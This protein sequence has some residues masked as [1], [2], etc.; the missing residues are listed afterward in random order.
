VRLFA[1]GGRAAAGLAP[2][3]IA[4]NRFLAARD[5]IGGSFV[6]LA[7]PRLQS[8]VERLVAL[9]D[10]CRPL[11]GE[12]RCAPEL[13]AVGA[14]VVNPGHARQRTLAHRRGVGGV[15]AGLSAELATGEPVS[16]AV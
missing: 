7:P 6:A 11:A 2:E 14:L 1:D 4:E 16:A 3:A 8:A 15:A 10:A 9:L 5:G 13:E 12:L